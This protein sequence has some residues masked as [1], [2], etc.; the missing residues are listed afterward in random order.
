MRWGVPPAPKP[1]NMAI[2]ETYRYPVCMDAP[3]ALVLDLLDWLEAEPRTHAA[4]ME[5]W[6]TSCPRL[7]V[8]EDALDAG[9]VERVHDG[10]YAMVRVTK[11]GRD[12]LAEQRS[13][14]LQ[15]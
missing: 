11:A 3:Q 1:G 14:R 2:S 8:W 7:P 15:S 12:L 9:L 13:R 4:V 5:A 6:H 10:A